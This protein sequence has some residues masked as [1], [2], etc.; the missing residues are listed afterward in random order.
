[1]YRLLSDHK[2]FAARPGDCRAP[3]PLPSM[4]WQNWQSALSWN[5][6]WPDEVSWA[7]ASRDS[8]WAAAATIIEIAAVANLLLEKISTDDMMRPAR[9]FGANVS[10]ATLRHVASWGDRIPWSKYNLRAMPVSR[11]K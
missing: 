4:P 2:E 10:D 1:M 8:S 3:D 6:R 11:T 5:R 7:A 9:A